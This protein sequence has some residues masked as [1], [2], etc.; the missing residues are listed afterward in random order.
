MF[1]C[2]CI[3]FPRVTKKFKKKLEIK[4]NCV[5]GKAKAGILF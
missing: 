4:R 1:W 2:E 5:G 3:H